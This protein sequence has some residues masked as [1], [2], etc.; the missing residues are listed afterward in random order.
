MLVTASFSQAASDES[1]LSQ[2]K[3]LGAPMAAVQRALQLSK[4]S[5]YSNKTFAVFDI[6]A[7]AGHKRFYLFDTR[8]GK[9]QSFFVAH[10]KAN[11]GGTR[12]TNFRGFQRNH[13]MTPLGPL[14]TASSTQSMAQYST[15]RD[16]YT[17]QA[18]HGLTTLWLEG[19]TS[20]NSYINSAT[21]GFSRVVWI[22][23]PAWYVTKGYRKNFP[24]ALGR[25]LGCIAMDPEV[26]NYVFGKLT[27]GA[28]VYVTVGNQPI[29]NFL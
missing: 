21:S 26:S 23:H 18:Y 4:T 11:G 6:S 12:A 10:G 9:V 5:A 20:Y 3:A 14:R 22:M 17:G 13:D 27:G 24:G 1:L 15:I 8:S 28:L 2:A 25:S 16:R 7:G 19:T 29:G